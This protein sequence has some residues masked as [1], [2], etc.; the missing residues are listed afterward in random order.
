MAGPATFEA[1]R[2][3]NGRLSISLDEAVNA[4]DGFRVE[5][6]PLG[7][8]RIKLFPPIT[9]TI[10]DPAKLALQGKTITFPLQATDVVIGREPM[11]QARREQPILRSGEAEVLGRT[12]LQQR[13]YTA[14]SASLKSGDVVTASGNTYALEQP[15]LVFATQNPIEQEGTYPLPEAQLDRFLFQIDVRYPSP[16]EEV[17]IVKRTTAPMPTTITPVLSAQDIVGFQDLVPRVPAA[18]HVVEHAVTL[19]RATRPDDGK[20]TELVRKNVA[21]GA[22]PRAS[23]GLIL[24]AKARAILHGRFAAEIE[25]VRALLEPIL[26]HRLVMNFR[27]EAEGVT[28]A[29]VIESIK[30]SIEP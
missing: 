11:I 12:A 21:F 1:V 28:P 4:R 10:A 7:G 13:V 30:Q 22:G 18:D 8:D 6:T 29:D 26:K 27:A 3:S 17:D 9:V 19:V 25:D 20:A 15:Y 14:K 24:G 5:I 16:N 23:Q 2:I